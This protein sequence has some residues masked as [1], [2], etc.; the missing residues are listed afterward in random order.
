MPVSTNPTKIDLLMRKSFYMSFLDGP[1]KFSEEKLP[2]NSAFFNELNQE[3][4][5]DENFVHVQT[6]WGKKFN[7]KEDARGLP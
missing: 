4:I 5:T 1:D 2:P 7:N 6:G 3:S